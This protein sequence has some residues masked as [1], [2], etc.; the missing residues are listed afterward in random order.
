MINSTIN[1]NISNDNTKLDV[2]VGFA[3]N[4]TG[5]L[6]FR[7]IIISGFIS[8]NGYNRNYSTSYRLNIFF[9]TLI[10]VSLSIDN[11]II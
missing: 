2:M 6:S 7:N 4:A 9:H 10:D 8:E 11:L 1:V 5:N 3:V